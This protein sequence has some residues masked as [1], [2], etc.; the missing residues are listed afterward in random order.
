MTLV[1][2]DAAAERRYQEIDALTRSI[3]HLG[4]L[5]TALKDESWRVRKLAAERLVEL[6]PKGAVVE[7]V[8][9]LLGL[10]DEVGTRNVAAAVLGQLG[11][12]AEAPVLTLLD[13]PDA[14]RRRLAA[15][16]LGQLGRAAVAPR[17]ARLIGDPDANVRVAA[18]EAL[19]HLGGDE[20]RR[21]LALLLASPD[22]LLRVCALEGLTEQRAPPPLPVLSAL[23]KDAW[24]RPSAFRLLGLVDHPTAWALICRALTSTS[25]RDAALG[26]LGVRSGVLSPEWELG[27][28]AVLKATVDAVPWLSNALDSEAPERRLGAMVAA[29]ALGDPR[30]A[31]PVVRAVRPGLE[32]D[33]A[34]TVLLRLGARGAGL[35]VSAKGA[36]AELPVPARLVV[37]E[38]IVQL[39]EPSLV[40][41]L[42]VLLRSGDPELAELATRALGRTRAR[43]AIPLL[44]PCFDVVALAPH[45]GRSV[46]TL[47]M[48]WPHEV[49]E[50]IAPL[51]AREP[52]DPHLVRAWAEVVKGDALEVL[53]RAST[54]PNDAVRAAVAE[55][56]P[57]VPVAA[58]A[59][60]EA[61]LSDPAPV[62]RRAAT[63]ILCRVNPSEARPLVLRALA[64]SDPVV[65]A[66][67]ATTAA[68][69]GSH[70]AI[71]AVAGL[72]HHREPGVVL[73]ALSALGLLDAL[74]DELLL[75]AADRGDAELEKHV[76]SLG[77]DRPVV[78][79]RALM[80]LAHPRADVRAAAAGVLAVA[81]G[82]AERGTL[83][84]ARSKE[85]DA[86]CQ[87]HLEVALARLDRG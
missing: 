17:L 48:S 66:L 33:V 49:R 8:V 30:L 18:A 26:A 7:Q 40:V 50:A 75:E 70:E 28:G 4:R 65:L 25:T 84:E 47:A 36:L 31:L 32:A 20:A 85:T 53:E 57:L 56:A 16:I 74:P 67:A 41:P 38:A 86:L 43:G 9:E 45:A 71:S 82:P 62:V 54:S 61:A 27:V 21:A 5:V 55:S 78:V 52:P 1:D 87:R 39:A 35:L 42:G 19:G 64:D 14:A 37:A 29:H 83:T 11:Q 72:A 51:V 6:E 44:L 81:A 12:E 63:S 73:A 23:L 80:R 79:A 34:M 76:F 59:L 2:A 3:E 68:E 46:A 24:A 60:L 22:P 69:L 10:H 58:Q 77:A 13:H 15:S